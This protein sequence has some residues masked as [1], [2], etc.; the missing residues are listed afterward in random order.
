MKLLVFLSSFIF[1]HS[2][3]SDYN[4]IRSECSWETKD[5]KDYNQFLYRFYETPHDYD[6]HIPTASLIDK[7][8][9]DDLN[10]VFANECHKND[11]SIFRFGPFSSVP[12]NM[13]SLVTYL[14]IPSDFEFFY[15]GAFNAPV[16]VDSETIIDYPPLHYHHT[17]LAQHLPQNHSFPNR[18]AIILPTSADKICVGSDNNCLI[19]SFPPDFGIPIRFPL[20]IDVVYNDVRASGESFDYWIES[21]VRWKKVVSKPVASFYSFAPIKCLNDRPGFYTFNVPSG[22]LSVMWYTYLSPVEGRVIANYWHSH[23]LVGRESWLF[24]G[25]LESL[26]LNQGEFVLEQP[27]ESFVAK[28]DF[29]TYVLSNLRKNDDISLK[30]VYSGRIE[31]IDGKP[32]ER[33]S[34]EHC[35]KDLYLKKNQVIS[36]ISFNDCKFCGEG[37]SARQHSDTMFYVATHG[38]QYTSYLVTGSDSIEKQ[39]IIHEGSDVLEYEKRSCER[40]G[41]FP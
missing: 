20:R 33:R 28:K 12:G 39:Y 31:W 3:Y 19:D 23:K 36:Q 35:I 38:S 6:K 16:A 5:A 2:Q 17:N 29:K 30:C 27:W 9:S 7:T 1:V 40:F 32:F 25:P 18:E 11:W 13:H 10:T 24:F 37:S 41:G 34:S 8:Y 15:T 26:G 4:S 22:V 21:A 14:P